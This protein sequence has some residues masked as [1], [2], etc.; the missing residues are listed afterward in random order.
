M[1]VVIMVRATLTKSDFLRKKSMYNLQVA[2]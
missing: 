1:F 2:V